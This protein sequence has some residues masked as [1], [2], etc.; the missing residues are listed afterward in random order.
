LVIFDGGM[1][2]LGGGTVSPGGGMPDRWQNA[3]SSRYG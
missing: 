3:V 1:A 2:T